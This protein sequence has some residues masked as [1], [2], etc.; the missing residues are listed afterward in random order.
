MKQE[1]K[2]TDIQ[3]NAISRPSLLQT[4]AQENNR[5]AD[6]VSRISEPNTGTDQD[7]FPTHRRRRIRCNCNARF[8][9]LHSKAFPTSVYV[10]AFGCQG[11]F[12]SSVTSTGRH[13]RNCPMYPSSLTVATAR[14]S[15]G[16]CGAI[17]NRAAEA[18]ISI[19]R[20]AGGF[21]I[22][23][24][25]HCSRLVSRECKAFGLVNL[26][27]RDVPHAS[28]F[29]DWEGFLDQITR[30]IE[31]LFRLGEATPYDVDLEGNTFL[32]VRSQQ[33]FL[34]CAKFHR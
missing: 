14:F 30:K 10:Q 28:T 27:R 16:I 12:R 4:A 15:I 34:H 22:S 18:S 20:G 26:Y 3:L 21:S 6:Y 2:I 32:H 23:P 29:G 1:R 33:T 19:I 13:H 9:Y 8:A 5:L 11:L 25:L 17:L 24:K 7:K 31:R